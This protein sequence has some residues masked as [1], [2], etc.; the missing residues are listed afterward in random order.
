MKKDLDTKGQCCREAVNVFCSDLTIV[1][2]NNV[3]L[4]M[5][6]LERELSVGV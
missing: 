5:I 3:I 6:E 1:D 2:V 4:E